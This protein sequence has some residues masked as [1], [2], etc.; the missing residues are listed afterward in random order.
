[1]HMNRPP[2]KGGENK[3]DLVRLKDGE[4]VTG[5]VVGDFH[6]YYAK[7]NQKYFEL[8]EKNQ[9]GSKFRFRVNFAVKEGAN[10][11]LRVIE[12]GGLLYE[13]LFDLN[14][15]FPLDENVITIKRRGSSQTETE[16][17][18]LASRKIKLTKEDVAYLATLAPMDLRLQGQQEAA[19]EL[20]KFNSI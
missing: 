6:T 16:Y 15:E 4:S 18:A 14:E 20:E 13:R 7:F 3:L 19:S 12:Q 10:W 5:I 17:S 1:V 11:I 8:S 2:G 9:P